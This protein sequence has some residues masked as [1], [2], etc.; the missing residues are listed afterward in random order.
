MLVELYRGI[1]MNKFLL[2]LA[3]A[4]A[5]VTAQAE[6]H[7][8]RIS[9]DKCSGSCTFYGSSPLASNELK[10]ALVKEPFIKLSNLFYIEKDKFKPWADWDDKVI[11]EITIRS[12]TVVL[13]MEYKKNPLKK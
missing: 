5:S 11:P 9:T 4:F 7:W 13:F 10:E 8:Y 2:A 3:L 1:T 12:S 6:D